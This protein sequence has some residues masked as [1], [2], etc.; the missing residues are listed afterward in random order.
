MKLKHGFFLVVMLQCICDLAGQKHPCPDTT[1]VFRYFD[2][3]SSNSRGR[4]LISSNPGYKFVSDIVN[5][6]LNNVYLKS[7]KAYEPLGIKRYL[8]QDKL[9]YLLGVKY[10]FV[11][12][13]DFNLLYRKNLQ[14]FIP[15]IRGNPY[16]EIFDM[17]VMDEKV[18]LHDP[19]NIYSLSKDLTEVKKISV[20]SLTKLFPGITEWALTKIAIK[21]TNVDYFYTN[22]GVSIVFGGKNLPIIQPVIILDTA[23]NVL[24]AR[25]I[26]IKTGYWFDNWKYVHMDSG[27]LDTFSLMNED[28]FY[29][30]WFCYKDSI[31]FWVHYI[32]GFSSDI[33]TDSSY[34]GEYARYVKH[35]YQ[36]TYTPV[37]LQLD[38]DLK[39]SNYLST[40]ADIERKGL[41]V[42]RPFGFNREV[43]QTN[44]V[45]MTLI[46]NGRLSSFH[47]TTIVLRSNDIYKY[48]PFYME[49]RSRIALMQGMDDVIET[50]NMPACVPSSLCEYVNGSLKCSSGSEHFVK[51]FYSFSVYSHAHRSTITK[52]YA[53]TDYGF[54][55]FQQLGDNG[56]S[57]LY[58]ERS[59][60]MI[61]IDSNGYTPYNEYEIKFLQ[62]ENEKFNISMMIESKGLGFMVP[63]YFKSKKSHESQ[64]YKNWE[65]KLTDSLPDSIKR[66]VHVIGGWD[67]YDHDALWQ[68]YGGLSIMK[69][70]I[71]K[72]IMIPGTYYLVVEPV[73]KYAD[74]GLV[75]PIVLFDYDIGYRARDKFGRLIYNN[76]YYQTDIRKVYKVKVRKNGKIKIKQV[77]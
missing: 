69:D 34:Q 42:K 47:V 70:S 57:Y 26:E 53:G 37:T 9:H 68:G 10:L 6:D 63:V 20:D 24:L 43:F 66:Q 60:M 1:A 36:D 77:Q 30:T 76:Y 13:S 32:K 14:D 38:L 31:R 46:R 5:P 22:G 52:C 51:D 3:S 25:K 71:Y 4:L 58:N 54:Y 44:R 64:Y 12:D 16:N 72:L 65:K 33:H 17:F 59:N 75:R 41:F 73:M 8:L 55:F 74:A 21:G 35:I 28:C 18:Y 48:Y 50:F 40:F 56:T 19:W 29:H 67:I 2:T 11:L 49:D 45:T 62:G 27:S 39:E 23:L 15:I 7:L 61:L